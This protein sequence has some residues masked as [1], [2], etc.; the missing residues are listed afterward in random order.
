MSGEFK[1]TQTMINSLL[2]QAANSPSMSQ[3]A[4]LD[5]LLYDVLYQLAQD[6]SSAQLLSRVEFLLGSLNQDE[7][8]VTRGC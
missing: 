7:I 5:A 2:E 1:L 4:M 6:Q 8:V 3:P